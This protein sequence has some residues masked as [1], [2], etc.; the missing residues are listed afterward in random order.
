MV[1]RMSVKCKNLILKLFKYFFL[2]TVIFRVKKHPG[3]KK[4]SNI[5]E[6]QEF[7]DD[8]DENSKDWWT[9]Y[10]YSFEKLIEDAKG[11]IP[12]RYVEQQNIEKKKLGVKGSKLVAKL[13]PK[14]QSNKKCSKNTTALCHVS[15]KLNCVKR[16]TH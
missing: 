10:F 2:I 3:K 13:S 9:K 15:F 8:D 16:R 1:L 11:S 5:D 7:E 12:H 6:S 4:H 14:H